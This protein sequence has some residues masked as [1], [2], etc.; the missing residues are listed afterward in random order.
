MLALFSGTPGSGKSVHA[1]KLAL[2]YLA[3]GRHVLLNYELDRSKIPN[4]ELYEYIPNGLLSV[5]DLKR[6]AATYQAG[7]VVEDSVLLV[8]DEAAS[9][10]NSRS[11]QQADRAD[12]LKFFTQS[13][14]MGYMVVL[15]A[16]FDRMLDKQLRELLQY[17]FV[18]HKVS[19]YGLMGWAF[20][21]LLG[22]KLHVYKQVYYP[23]GD[24]IGSK[25]FFVKKKVYEIY[26]SYDL[27]AALGT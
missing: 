6:R 17:D 18:H 22:G 20:G 16:Q 7:G 10:F 5:D 25:Y 8:I 26:D 9:V 19:N 11:W 12:W 1:T 2:D 23:T 13:R 27:V 4:P 24:T 3:K 15:V 14:K 21:S